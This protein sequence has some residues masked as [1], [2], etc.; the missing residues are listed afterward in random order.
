MR[1]LKLP[2][3]VSACGSERLKA[4]IAQRENATWDASETNSY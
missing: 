2:D 1:K 4:A 3:D